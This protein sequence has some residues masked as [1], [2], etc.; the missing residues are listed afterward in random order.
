VAAKAAGC[1][2][3][4]FPPEDLANLFEEQRLDFL[5]SCAQNVRSQ[6][7]KDILPAFDPRLFCSRRPG[8]QRHFSLQA[9]FY[10]M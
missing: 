6:L 2:L 7:G 1:Y 3:S 4:H 10:F 9:G 5:R 8:R